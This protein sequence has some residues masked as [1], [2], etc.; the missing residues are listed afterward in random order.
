MPQNRKDPWKKYKVRRCRI[1]KGK[2]LYHF[3]SLGSMPIPNGFLS[4]KDLTIKEER[5][6]LEVYVCEDCWLVQLTHVIPAE[7]MFK[8]Y[9]YIPSTSQTMLEHFKAFAVG[10]VDEYGLKPN[11]LIVD[12]GS[13]DGTLLGYFREQEMRVLG[14]DP[15]SNIAQVARLKGIDTIDDFFTEELAKKIDKEYG[16]A[17]VVTATNAVAHINDLHGLCQGVRLLLD[18]DGMF[19]MEYPY[20]ADLLD[21]NEFDTIYHEHLSYFAIRPLITL[22]KQHGMQ[23]FDI[24][25][26]PVHGGSILVYVSK[27]GSRHTPK[28]TVRE[29]VQ[30]ELLK[31]LNKKEA[32]DEFARRVAGIKRDLMEYLKSLK[33][34]RKRIVGYGAAAKGNVLL[35][36]CGVTSELLSYIVDSIPY[37]QGRYTPGTHI[38]IYPEA[39]LAKDRPDYTLLLAW[40][41][42]DEILKK[43]VKYRENGGQFI[44]TIPYLR[45]E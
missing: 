17:K 41:F 13:N 42:A 26:T 11:D 15:A 25:R 7:I 2:R 24:K 21:K 29:F 28:D 22:F 38:P 36:Y 23:I 35:N 32:Y 9:L 14:V 20:L 16:K 39:R 34:Q 40:N 12:I 3:L 8:N 43:Q 45:V 37:K 6:P 44:I 4:R 33:S 31:K 30:L 27:K 19:V 18:K 1:C 10:L 5:Y